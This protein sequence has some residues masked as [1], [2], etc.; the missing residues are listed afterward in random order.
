M[1][2]APM[3]IGIGPPL[4]L[5]GTGRHTLLDWA[6]RAEQRGFTTLGAIDR[7]VYDSLEPL[8]ALCAAAAVTDRIEL[9]TS[10][11]LGPLRPNHVLLAKQVATLDRLS[12]GRLVLGLAPASAR[13]TSPTAPAGSGSPTSPTSATRSSGRP[14]RDQPAPRHRPG[15]SPCRHLQASNSMPSPARNQNA[16]GTRSPPPAS[17][18]TTCTG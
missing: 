10:V 1:T 15:R 16:S 2:G 18:W 6:R 4:T 3:R 12:A 11:L 14:R 5:P 7:P 17:L 9:L 13:T 8:A